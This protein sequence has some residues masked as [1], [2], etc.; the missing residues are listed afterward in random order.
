VESKLNKKNIKNLNKKNVETGL[1]L[2]EGESILSEYVKF[3]P[4]HIKKI[5][6]KYLKD[7]AKYSKFKAK[8]ISLESWEKTE[9]ANYRRPTSPVFGLVDVPELDSVD[10]LEKLRTT[11]PSLVVMLDHIQDP[12][13]LGAIAR[14]L[15]FFGIDTLIIPNVRQARVTDFSLATSQGAFAHVNL[16]VVANLSRILED[17]KKEGYWVLGADMEGEPAENLAGFYSKCCLVLG[18]EDKGISKLI[19]E[20]CDRMIS[21]HRKSGKL[22]SLNVSVAA[23][24]LVSNLSS[25]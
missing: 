6:C 17:I 21:V 16:Y 18:S 25:K 14:S 1:F 3:A 2:I 19:K 13:N 22:E 8:L 10:L 15:A 4:H 20:K 12:R 24:I 23:G 9:S 11:Q 7:E 5:C